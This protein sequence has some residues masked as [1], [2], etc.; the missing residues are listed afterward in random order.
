M[1]L[2]NCHSLTK[3]N[4]NNWTANVQLVQHKLRGHKQ[5][6][7][8]SLSHTPRSQS[9]QTNTSRD[10]CFQPQGSQNT[11]TH[12]I[13]KNFTHKNAW[14]IAFQQVSFKNSTNV[15]TVFVYECYT[16]GVFKSNS[17]YFINTAECSQI[18]EEAAE[19]VKPNLCKLCT[20]AARQVSSQRNETV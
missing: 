3:K 2:L 12:S 11:L 8:K 15:H 7:I 20:L 6:P 13:R 16:T 4:I 1:H 14:K 5:N 10:I 18:N 19:E 17:L 9:R